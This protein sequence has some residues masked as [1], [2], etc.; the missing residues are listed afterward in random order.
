MPEEQRKLTFEEALAIL[1]RHAE[2]DVAAEA[3]K[4]APKKKKVAKAKDALKEGAKQ[5]RGGLGRGTSKQLKALE[6]DGY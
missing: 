2:E 5:G 1:D 3:A 6:E 4:A